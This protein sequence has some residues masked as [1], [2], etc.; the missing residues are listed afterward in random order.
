MHHSRPFSI[1]LQLERAALVL[2]ADGVIPPKVKKFSEENYGA[3]L[4]TYTNAMKAITA[5]Q[6]D[7]ILDVYD[8]ANED[9]DDGCNTSVADN[10]RLNVFSFESP[11]KRR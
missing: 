3:Q 11:R 2:N 7:E 1:V 8:V 9:V 10:D 5:D 4:Q 6:W